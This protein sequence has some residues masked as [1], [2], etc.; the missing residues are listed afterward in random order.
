MPWGWESSVKTK[1]SR[2]SS[3]RVPSESQRCRRLA[4]TDHAHVTARVKFMEMNMV[5]GVPELVQ[6]G[7]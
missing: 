3:I 6:E 1:L 7:Q 5:A 2:L 4:G